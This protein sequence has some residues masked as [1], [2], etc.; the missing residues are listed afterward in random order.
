MSAPYG[1]TSTSFPAD[2]KW[3]DL[4]RVPKGQHSVQ[5][6]IGLAI[7]SGLADE[8][9]ARGYQ[10]NSPSLARRA[11][12]ASFNCK[13]TRMIVD[14]FLTANQRDDGIIECKLEPLGWRRTWK[15]PPYEEIWREWVGMR[16]LIDEFL[17][18]TLHVQ[19]LRWERVRAYRAPTA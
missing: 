19:P 6:Q 14:L 17:T 2:Q 3:V 18:K 5:A 16:T 7:L 1:L 8:L 13:S 4:S 15:M 9:R 11:A 12:I 10:V